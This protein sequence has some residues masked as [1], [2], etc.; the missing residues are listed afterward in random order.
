MS[1]S[2]K[3]DKSRQ[4]WKRVLWIGDWEESTMVFFLQQLIQGLAVGSIYGLIAIGLDEGDLLT[5][6]RVTSGRDDLIAATRKGMA[7]RFHEEDIR[8]LSRTARGVRAIRLSQGDEIVGMSILREGGLVLTVT[9][10][11]FGRLS[12]QDNYRVQKRGGKGLLNYHTEKFGDVAAIKVVDMDDDIILIS[13]DGVIIRIAASSVR[14]CARPSK[15][16]RVMKLQEGSKVATLARVPH[17]E[18]EVDQVDIEDDGT[19]D[20]GGDLPESP[21][22]ELEPTTEE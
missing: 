22:E 7:I 9:E 1:P 21:E 11:G 19:A 4:A 12:E 20:E 18:D 16:V 13:E 10:T 3:P 17:E 15:G 8:E 2:A 6:V 14:V 5:W